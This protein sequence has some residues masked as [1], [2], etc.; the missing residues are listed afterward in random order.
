MK[1]ALIF[2]SS[3]ALVVA[4]CSSEPADEAL[5]SSDETAVVEEVEPVSDADEELRSYLVGAWSFEDNCAN[6]FFV[7]Y[8][9]DGSLNSVGSLGTWHIEDGVVTDTVTAE[10][11]YDRDGST[12]VDPPQTYS[13]AVERID[14]DHAR[15]ITDEDEFTILRC[16][17]E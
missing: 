13:Y 14:D 17:S 16:S 11:D 5:E 2:G 12:P 3:L 8:G 6:D 10:T 9:A 7:R 4:A 15:L 1:R